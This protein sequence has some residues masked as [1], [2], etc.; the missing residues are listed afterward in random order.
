VYKK[1]KCREV[2]GHFDVLASD[3]GKR[4]P[5]G[6]A[7]SSKIEVLGIVMVADA[8]VEDAVERRDHPAA[9][10][11]ARDNIL[12]RE[13][14]I[15]R[16][17][18]PRIGRLYVALAVAHARLD[19]FVVKEQTSVQGGLRSGLQLELR[20]TPWS[21]IR[22]V[23]ERLAETGDVDVRLALGEAGKPVAVPS[24]AVDK[25]RIECLTGA[26]LGAGVVD[27]EIPG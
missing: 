24:R 10:P 2:L 7:P 25:A 14:F 27:H 21:R 8:E 17:S 3:V 4:G 19:Q 18:E 1:S 15:L 22:V 5:E 20:R 6:V 23:G 13:P 11:D 9:A 16:M 26:Q 12:Q